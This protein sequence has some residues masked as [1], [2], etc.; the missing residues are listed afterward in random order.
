MRAFHS[1]GRRTGPY[2]ALFDAIPAT[3]A[4]QLGAMIPV[5]RDS[6]LRRVLQMIESHPSLN[7]RELALECNLSES[8]LRHLVKQNTGFGLGRLLTE[9]RMQCATALLAN[10]KNEHSRRSPA[11]WVLSIRPVSVARLN[12]IFG[13]RQAAT[14]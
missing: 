5:V 14:A 2:P 1:A 12:A 11:P 8:H 7:I 6:R 13:K 4:A 3:L 9:Q 10:S